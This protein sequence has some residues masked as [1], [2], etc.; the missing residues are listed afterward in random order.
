[1]LPEARRWAVPLGAEG[2]T[3][4]VCCGRVILFPPHLSS[5]SPSRS[6]QISFRKEQATLCSR[7]CAGS[8]PGCGGRHRWEASVV[9][10]RRSSLR[11]LGTQKE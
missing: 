8:E 5:K 7:V 9:L 4:H 1:M 3:Y 6:F 2:G 11:L 10:A